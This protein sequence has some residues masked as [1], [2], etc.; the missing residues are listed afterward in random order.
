MECLGIPIIILFVWF[1][2]L[3]KEVK[4]N[5]KRIEDL[6]HNDEINHKRIKKLRKKLKNKDQ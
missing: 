5:R 4:E 1:F 3:T 2:Y 6:E